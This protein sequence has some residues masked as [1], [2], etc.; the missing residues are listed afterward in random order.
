MQLTCAFGSE[1]DYDGDCDAH[2]HEDDDSIGDVDCDADDDYGDDGDDDGNDDGDVLI[3]C[4][5][6]AV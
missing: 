1:D 4:A 6:E 2:N 5:A 3:L